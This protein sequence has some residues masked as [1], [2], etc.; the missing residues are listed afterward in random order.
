MTVVDGGNIDPTK[1]NAYRAV[2][3]N[4][5]SGTGTRVPLEGID[6]TDETVGTTTANFSTDAVQEFN[7]SRSSFDL[8]T[9]LTTS[10]AV[11]IASR[12]GGNKFSGSG[13]YFKQ[14]DRFDARPA[15]EAQKLEFNRDQEW[16]SLRRTFH[17]GQAV[18]FLEFRTF[19]PGELCFVHVGRLSAI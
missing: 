12:T 17:K 19:Q 14:D 3:V 2:Q 9:S 18:L 11:S 15:F 10:G 1:V 16:V 7:L 8:S 4:G 6:V 5:G 13:F